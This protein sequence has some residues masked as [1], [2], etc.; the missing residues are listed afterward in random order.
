MRKLFLVLSL[1]SV[2]AWRLA[3]PASILAVEQDEVDELREQ[4]DDAEDEIDDA[5]SRLDDLEDE[6]DDD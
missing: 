1:G 5:R 3:M 4:L 2:L 6:S